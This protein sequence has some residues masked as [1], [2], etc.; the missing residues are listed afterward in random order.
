MSTAPL[1]SATKS[2][3]APAAPE[4]RDIKNGQSFVDALRTTKPPCAPAVQIDEKL[5]GLPFQP[6][7]KLDGLPFQPDEKLDG[8][9]FELDEKLDGLPFELDGKGQEKARSPADPDKDI[10]DHQLLLT[11]R[12]A[13]QLLSGFPGL[14]SG[15]P[16]MPDRD[17][18]EG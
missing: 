17:S 15:L 2:F 6:D 10:V 7:E 16:Y 9:P 13:Y 3:Q 8:L 12:L 18:A 5:D 1:N 4:R 14:I 11:H